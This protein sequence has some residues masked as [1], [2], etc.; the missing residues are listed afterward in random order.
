MENSCL[1]GVQGDSSFYGN[2]RDTLAL[3]LVCVEL[4][5][6][7]L[8]HKLKQLY[9]Y[10][11]VEI[12]IDTTYIVTD[13]LYELNPKMVDQ[14]DYTQNHM[15]KCSIAQEEKRSLTLSMRNHSLLN[16]THTTVK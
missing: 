8:L 10:L 11:P 14:S 2:Q 12:S 13:I 7:P 5:K 4:D 1:L 9:R 3:P 16:H 15:M 6:I